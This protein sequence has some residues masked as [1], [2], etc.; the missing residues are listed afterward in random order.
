M[1]G[2][3]NGHLP[4]RAETKEVIF[5][6]SAKMYFNFRKN[7]KFGCSQKSQIVEIF[8]KTFSSNHPST[9][10]DKKPPFPATITNMV[11]ALPHIHP[12]GLWGGGG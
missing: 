3:R 8:A 6:L 4:T 5:V 7:N 1:V 10:G 12:W 9:P 2:I 11:F